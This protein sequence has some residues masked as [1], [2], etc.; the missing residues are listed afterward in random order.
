[1]SDPFLG[2]IRMVGFTFAPIGWAMCNGNLM[3]ISQ[4][5]ALFALLGTT[6]GGNGTSTFGLP[7]LQGRSPVGTGNGIG[8][9]PILP[10]EKAGTESTAL[11]VTQMPAHTHTTG[12]ANV[13]VTGSASI[14]ACSSPTSGSQSGTPGPTTVLGTSVA[15]GRPGEL[16]TTTASNTNLLPFNVQSTGTVAGGTT[17]ATGGSQPF[18]IRNPYLGLTCIIALQG[19]FPS[20]G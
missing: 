19:I 5:N 14:P 2:E 20:R 16:Y 3:S 4:N 15:G 10:G 8:L 12:G 1:M 17:G 11:L 9:S 7:D 13:T 6:Y 18:S